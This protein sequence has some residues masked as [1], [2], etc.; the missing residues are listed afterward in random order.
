M[1]VTF[2]QRIT[3]QQNFF[4]GRYGQLTVGVQGRTYQPTNQFPAGTPEALALADRN[5][6]S[7]FVLDD[8]FSGQ[9]PNPIPYIGADGVQR[10]GDAIVGGLTGVLD[11]GAINSNTSIRDYRLQPTVAPTFQSINDRTAK[12]ERVGGDLKIASFNVLNYF[13]TFTGSDARGANSPAEFERQRAKIFAAMAAI[14]ADVFG[15]MEIQNSN[16]ALNNLVTGLNEYLGAPVYAAVNDTG[17]NV[18]TDAIKVAMI[19]KTAT[20]SPVGPA[21]SYPDDSFLGQGRVP[22]AQTFEQLSTGEQLSVVVNHFKSKGSCPD[23]ET[24]V[25]ADHGQGCWNALRVEE[26]HALLDYIGEIQ[27][28]SGDDD[29]LVIGDLNAYAK[30]DPILVLEAAGLVNEVE[31][32]VGKKAYSYVFDGLAGYLDH[33]LATPSLHRQIAGATEW[34]INADEPS[35]I[36]Y[37]LE[38]KPQDLYEATPYRSSDHDP[39]IVGT[40]LR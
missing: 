19:Y 23:S 28:A 26:A 27:Q 8:A 21:S 11:F 18:G 2:P 12:P 30:E 17:L 31:R 40:R 20:V 29:V 38:F 33:A 32:W 16:V 37:N 39:V 3:V 15:L 13:T 4:L 14:D 1:L 7:M 24:D 10:A 9:N 36:D 5:R 25:N 6:R 35:V 22:V 34:H